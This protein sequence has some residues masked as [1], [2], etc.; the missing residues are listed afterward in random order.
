M[1]RETLIGMQRVAVSILETVRDICEKYDI[2]FYLGF[3]SALGAVRHGGVIPWDDDIDILMFESEVLKFKEAFKKELPENLF[4]QDYLTDKNFFLK[5]I[6]ICDNNST[7][8]NLDYKDVEMHYGLCID[9]FPLYKFVDTKKN[10]EKIWR[11]SRLLS[12]VVAKDVMKDKKRA[13]LAK[14]ACAIFG[15]ES[16]INYLTNKLK[17]FDCENA[18]TAFVIEQPIKNSYIPL[19][20]FDIDSSYSFEG[21]IYPI[22]GDYD[23]YLSD[24]YGDY[25]TLPPEDKRYAHNNLFVDLLKPYTEYV[26]KL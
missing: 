4:Y 10:R 7:A 11:T 18:D 15:R 5:M 13:F 26:G 21:G 20:Y 22:V 25:M 14:T 2:K 24:L 23:S 16:V 3:G 17:S 19:K 6:K 1:D 8:I 12:F 9:I